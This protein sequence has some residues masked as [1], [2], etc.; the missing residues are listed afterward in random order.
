MR[1]YDI[2]FRTNFDLRDAL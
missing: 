1:R 2:W